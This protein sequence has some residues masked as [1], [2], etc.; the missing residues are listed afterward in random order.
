MNFEDNELNI[1]ADDTAWIIKPNNVIDLF[2]LAKQKISALH[3]TRKQM[4]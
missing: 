4:V 3:D 1:Y 2:K